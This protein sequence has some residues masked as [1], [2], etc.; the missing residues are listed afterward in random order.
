MPTRR[1]ARTNAERDAALRNGKIR[2]DQVPPML[3]IPYTATTITRIDTFQPQY[4]LKFQA[5]TL[6][7]KAQTD[8]SPLIAD[9]LQKAVWYQLDFIEALNKAIRRGEFTAS[10]RTLYH[11]DAN[12]STLPRI[13]TESDVTTWGENIN[14]G[15]TARIAGGGAPITF[16]SLAQVNTAVAAFNTLNA[17]QA[18]AKMLYDTAQ[19]E[20]EVLNPEADKLIL[21]MWNETETAFDEGDKP[22]MRRKCR[23][24]GVVYVPIPGEPISPEEYSIIGTTTDSVTGLP[25]DNVAY[26]LLPPDVLLLGDAQGKYFIGVLPEGTYSLEALK[27]GYEGETI[28]GI[29]VTDGSITT[30]DFQLTPESTGNISGT[31]TQ[32]GVPVAANITI[33]GIPGGVTTDPSGNYIFNDIP[34]GTHNVRAELAS[35]P[36]IFQTQT[37]TIMPGITTTVNFIFP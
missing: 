35:N 34:A 10:D 21:K 18:V 30:V 11:L 26:R 33:T 6:A 14:D 24:W 7:K 1:L 22:S 36:S 3:V 27:P 32:G 2:K 13:T 19:E 31:V 5:V 28:T 20:L 12:D 23:E 16:P 9:A 37:I 29:V 15:E 8:L 4:R 17:Q 25:I